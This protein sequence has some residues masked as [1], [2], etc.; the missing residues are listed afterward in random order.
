MTLGKGAKEGQKAIVR[1]IEEARFVAKFLG[2]LIGSENVGEDVRFRQNRRA[3][4]VRQ[5][6]L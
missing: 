4:G 5:Q 6:R 3:N 2:P 1:R